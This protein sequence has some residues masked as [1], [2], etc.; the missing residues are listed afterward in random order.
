MPLQKKED[1]NPLLSRL[2][3]MS[4]F[5]RDMKKKKARKAAKKRSSSADDKLDE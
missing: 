3:P 1:S 5:I 2:K 4:E